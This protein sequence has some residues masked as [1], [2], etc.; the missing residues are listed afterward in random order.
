ME[1]VEFRADA[2]N[3]ASI[4]AMK[5]IGCIEEGVLRSHTPTAAGTRRDSMVLSIL[6]NEWFNGVKEKITIRD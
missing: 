4:T 3:A 1:R 6:R 5:A 2:K